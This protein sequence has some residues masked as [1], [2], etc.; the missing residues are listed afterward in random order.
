MNAW[1]RCVGVSADKAVLSPGGWAQGSTTFGCLIRHADKERVRESPARVGVRRAAC[2]T[3]AASFPDP[4]TVASLKC[5]QPHFDEAVQWASSMHGTWYAG[6]DNPI[7][8]RDASRGM[9][10]WQRTTAGALKK[11]GPELRGPCETQGSQEFDEGFHGPTWHSV[12]RRGMEL[13][14]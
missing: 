9:H 8:H 1:Q 2:H 11:S 7:F 12:G 6:G 4:R 10:R 13:S 5:F 3:R 14:C